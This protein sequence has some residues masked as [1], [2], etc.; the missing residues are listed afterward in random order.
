MV[1]TRVTRMA[2]GQKEREVHLVY[3]SRDVRGAGPSGEHSIP[4]AVG[5]H[6]FS[7]GD[8]TLHS[9][10]RTDAGEAWALRV[11]GPR[12][13]RDQQGTQSSAEANGAG[14]LEVLNTL[15]WS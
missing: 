12:P 13:R 4:V 6:L 9:P 10:D 2:E 15:T 1:L 14:L 3:A 7:N 8:L 5:I 11:G